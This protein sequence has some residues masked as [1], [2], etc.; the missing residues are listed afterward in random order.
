MKKLNIQKL[1]TLAIVISVMTIPAI[2]LAA[3]SINDADL[4]PVSQQVTQQSGETKL[5]LTSAKTLL[6]EL[7]DRLDTHF[8]QTK[9]QASSLLKLAA[10][11]DV[12]VAE[13][14]DGYISQI[15]DLKTRAHNASTSTELKAVAKDVRTLIQEARQQVKKN[16]SQRISNRIAQFTQKTQNQPLIQAAQKRINTLQSQGKNVDAANSALQSCQALIQQGNQSLQDAK[17]EFDQVPGTNPQDQQQS[18]QLVIQG[19]GKV[20][21]ARATYLN[22]RQSCAGVLKQ[23]RAAR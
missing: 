15:Q 11:N 12:D 9:Q 20:K 17:S 16:I 7:I 5:D 4:N 14:I 8:Q 23:I 13:T 19:L 2:S 22:A 18:R 1:T 6:L 21:Q 3:T 10:T